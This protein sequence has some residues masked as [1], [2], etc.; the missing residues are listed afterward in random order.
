MSVITSDNRD[1]L[2]GVKYSFLNTNYT[3][4][5]TSLVVENSE[6]FKPNDF[7][8]IGEW[9]S[10]YTEIRR[11]ESITRAT[12]TLIVTEATNFSHAESTKVYIINYDQARFFHTTTTTFSAIDPIRDYVV[13]GDET[14]QF[15]ITNPSGTTARYTYDTTGTDPHISKYVRVGYT[16]TTNAEN[17][18]AG[19]NKTLV[20]TAVGTNYFEAVNATVVAETNKTIGTGSI[21]VLTNY[22]DLD[23]SSF[24][25]KVRDS[26]NSTGYGWFVF[27]N[28]YTE[29]ASQNS[30]AI[31]YAGFAEN[32]VRSI[33]DGF[34]SLLNN[35]EL[36]LVTRVDA[37]SWLNEAYSIARNE[38]NLV[39]KSYGG[40]E[41]YTIT[42]GAGVGEYSL[43]DN[44]SDLLSVV[45]DSGVT[46]GRIDLSEVSSY[47]QTSSNEIKYYL[48]EGYIGFTPT[49]TETDTYPVRYVKKTTAL[50]S[51]YDN[52]IMP[53]NN[54]Y[55][56]KDYMLFRASPKLGRGDG[57][58][59][60]DLFDNEIKRM[61]L[62]SITQDASLD[63]WGIS[64]SSNI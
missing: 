48:R 11:I 14:T 20:V 40:S 51:M 16:I 42:V 62:T 9:G 64:N 8:L 4:D 38:L 58:M 6:E 31:P 50:N 7:I 39:N 41:E 60:K 27:Y 57:V 25:T 2:K 55:C 21:T 35:K 5:K 12:N 1:L 15:D 3:S 53:D 29:S 33:L 52:V 54:F 45:D 26:A 47:G 24:T 61:K 23:T 22:L 28:S 10:S 18:S 36:K 44:F 59:Y 13:L 49:P 19:N 30:N 56:M 37:L 32:S 43:P 46:L 17:F 63:S 34:F